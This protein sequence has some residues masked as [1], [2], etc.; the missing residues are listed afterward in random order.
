MHFFQEIV[1]H[2]LTKEEVSVSFPNLKFSVSE[3]LEIEC[4]DALKKIK[5][6]IENDS[7]NDFECVEEIVCVFEKLGSG[8]GNRHD[9]G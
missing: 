1:A 2:V 6:I 4:F 9:F 7:L 5:A 3:L 8:G